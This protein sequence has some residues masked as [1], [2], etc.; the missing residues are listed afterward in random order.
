[1]RAYLIRRLVLIIPTLV[2]LTMIVFLSV[3]FIPG[4]VIDMIV[5]EVN[6]EGVLSYEEARDM[7]REEL[8]L[9]TP[10]PEDTT[11]ERVHF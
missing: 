6:I 7:I 2:L 3:R 9:D 1:M 10:L 8:G 11:D 5:A 4:D